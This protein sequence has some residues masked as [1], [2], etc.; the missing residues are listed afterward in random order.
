MVT[1]AEAPT[2]PET[3]DSYKPA[4]K[5]RLELLDKICSNVR[6][7]RQHL[8]VVSCI[9]QMSRY[10]LNA[11]AAT[12][13][14]L[15]EDNKSALNKYTDG[16]LG[17]QFQ[18]FHLNKQMGITR[19]VIKHGKPC[20]IEDID[21]EKDSNNTRD[22]VAGVV[23]RS[24][25][26][27][28]LMANK[29]VIGAIEVLNK[30]DGNSFT[31]HDV[32][33]LTGLADNAALTIENI[34]LNEDLLYSYKN[35]VEKLVSLLDIR[36]STAGQHSRRV[37]E[38][39]LIAANELGLS[40]E[41]KQSIE[42]AAILHDIG[43][44]SIPESVLNKRE[45]LTDEEW[46]MIRKHPVIGYNLLRGIPSLNQVSKLILYHHER[47]DGKGYPCGLKGKTIPVGARI[48]AIADAFDSM[49]MKHT[50]RKAMT[51]RDAMEE[52]GRCSA[53]Q[54]CPTVVRA[55]FMGYVKARKSRSSSRVKSRKKVR[56]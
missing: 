36:E 8:P 6:S 53:S 15:D 40:E 26:C 16:P 50:Y 54:F 47:Y 34:R 11:S 18:R 56:R 28:P 49:T 42:Y 35:T 23:P 46:D 5:T 19:R 33:V 22:E 41:E 37:A 39:A 17:K 44:L 7:V 29:E 12:L 27:V 13:I 48:I 38:Y 43:L 32:Q 20:L 3:Q 45:K 4:T 21:K 1:A 9:A 10:A 30:L 2:A 25:V 24:M 31:E 51:T 52:I 14:L 55:F